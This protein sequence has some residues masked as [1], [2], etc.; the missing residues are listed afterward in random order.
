[1]FFLKSGWFVAAL[2]MQ[3]EHPK[4]PHPGDSQY[5]AC[6]SISGRAEPAS[7]AGIRNRASVVFPGRFRIQDSQKMMNI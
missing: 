7:T 5:E 3:I 4:L 2:V 1:M 6:S